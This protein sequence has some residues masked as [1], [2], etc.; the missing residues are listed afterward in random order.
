MG[1]VDQWAAEKA[2]AEWTPAAQAEFEERLAGEPSPRA[3]RQ[4]NRSR[5]V[6]SALVAAALGFLVTSAV[7]VGSIG[8]GSA[9]WPAEASAASPS[10]LLIA[11]R[12][13]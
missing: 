11:D 9:K 3:W 2:S 12:G 10:V 1:E 8:A 13:R 4:R 5:L 7:E 6:G